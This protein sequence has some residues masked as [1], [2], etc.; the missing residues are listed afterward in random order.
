MSRLLP[1][2]TDAWGRARMSFR[3]RQNLTLNKAIAS[4][5]MHDS[6]QSDQPQRNM[7]A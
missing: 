6:P 7:E 4:Y 1:G 5:M 3:N 2:T